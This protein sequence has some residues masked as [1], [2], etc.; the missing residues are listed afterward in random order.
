MVLTPINGVNTLSVI[1]HAKLLTGLPAVSTLSLI[2]RAL[3]LALML[4]HHQL[5]TA[6]LT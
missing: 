5:L 4:T 1:I 3:F 6:V 2:S